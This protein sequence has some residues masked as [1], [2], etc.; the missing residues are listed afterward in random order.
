MTVNLP[1]R[2]KKTANGMLSFDLTE[3]PPT[4]QEIRAEQQL[5][6]AEKKRLIINSCLSDG[7]HAVVF[8]ALYLSDQLSG[9]GLLVALA[10][11]TVIALTL[12]AVTRRDLRLSDRIAIAAIAI[13]SAAAVSVILFSLMAETVIGSLIAG[14]AAGSIVVTGAILGRKIKQVMVGL[15]ELRSI[16]ED[17]YAV[18]EV[19]GICRLYPEMEEYRQQALQILRPNLTYGELWAMQKWAAHHQPANSGKPPTDAA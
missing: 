15:E 11:A 5:L 2:V 10:L 4:M 6:Q 3:E 14:L 8:L 9:Y 17:D 1:P 16:A 18:Q 13:G 19:T 12:A 7:L